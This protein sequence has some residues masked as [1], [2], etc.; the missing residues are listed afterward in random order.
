M[1]ED[2]RRGRRGRDMEGKCRGRYIARDTLSMEG[3]RCG[4]EHRWINTQTRGQQTM[5][6]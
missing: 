3:E 2:I 1:G 6:P 4:K 5:A